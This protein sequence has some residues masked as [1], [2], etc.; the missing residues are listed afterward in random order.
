MVFI[1]MKALQR[2]IN[3]NKNRHK[4]FLNSSVDLQIND[5]F[6]QSKFK[7]VIEDAYEQKS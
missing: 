4:Y 1:H 6:S 2:C 5:C 3:I 7:W